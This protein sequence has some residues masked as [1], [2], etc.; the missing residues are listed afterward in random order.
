[1]CIQALSRPVVCLGVCVCMS[2]YFLEL[3]KKILTLDND[4][5]WNSWFK[6]LKIALE[7]QSY[8]NTILAKYYDEIKLNFFSPE[9]W[10]IFCDIYDFLQPFFRVT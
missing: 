1:M 2:D 10:R 5:R 9:D 4:T 7:L 3:I 8:I 6:I